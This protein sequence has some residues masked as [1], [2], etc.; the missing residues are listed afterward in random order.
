MN[1]TGNP[2]QQLADVIG[3]KNSGV[4]VLPQNPTPDGIAAATALYL[5]LSK[6]G[7][8]LSIVCS[9]P[10]KSELAAADKIQT[11]FATGGDNLVVSFPYTEGAVDKVEY[12]GNEGNFFN[13][14]VIP[15]AGA[16]KLDPKKVQFSFTGGRADFI[17][18]IDAPNFR[19]LGQ[20][21]A[22]NQQEFNGKTIINIDRHL[23]NDMYG[24]VNLIQKTSSSTS[25]LVLRV[26]QGL[27]IE[28]DREIATNLYAGL[29]SA[30]ANFTS[31]SV[32]A[33]TFETAAN[34]LKFGAMKR[35]TRPANMNMPGTMPS[36]PG[37]PPMNPPMGMP[38]MPRRQAP[39]GFPAGPGPVRGEQVTPIEDVEDEPDEQED[40]QGQQAAPQD[41]LKPKIFR[42]GGL[43]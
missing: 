40:D 6:L 9:S 29:A 11:T 1:P 43:I 32:N 8:N 15:R 22:E 7:K 12:G 27:Q 36:I 4:I 25:E 10:V 41:W 17:I 23:V 18:T 21:Y 2:I 5:G 26:L 35:P 24:T 16:E 30:T 19:S 34:L 13:I 20:I 33:G 37:M 38:Q 39:S 3:K 31:Y 14:I 42:G 28:I